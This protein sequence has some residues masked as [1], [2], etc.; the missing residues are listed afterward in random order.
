MPTATSTRSTATPASSPTGTCG[1]TSCAARS[2][3]AL[4]SYDYDSILGN[5][6]ANQSS[7]SWTV[8]IFY[9][10]LPKLDVGAEYRHA[11]AERENGDDGKLDRVQLTTKY[12]F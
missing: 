3:Y 8:N 5:S 4:E 6:T 7:D 9:S 2:T 1:P 12:S 10:P 11:S